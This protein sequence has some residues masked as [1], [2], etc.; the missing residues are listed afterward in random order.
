MKTLTAA[1]SVLLFLF[2]SMSAFAKTCFNDAGQVVSCT[3]TTVPEPG[4]LA[5]LAVGAAVGA[6]V[7]LRNRNK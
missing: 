1:Q 2:S 7:W 3:P 4:S 5:L 6:A